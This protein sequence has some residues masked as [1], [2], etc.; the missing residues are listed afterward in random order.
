MSI[1]EDKNVVRCFYPLITSEFGFKRR[2]GPF[3]L[4]N[5]EKEKQKIVE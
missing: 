5:K 3:S 4:K 2:S 1:L